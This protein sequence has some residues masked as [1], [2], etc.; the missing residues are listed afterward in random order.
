MIHELGSKQRIQILPVP[1]SCHLEQ[2]FVLLWVS[3]DPAVDVVVLLPIGAEGGVRPD[4]A[5]LLRA[6]AHDLPQAITVS[7]RPPRLDVPHSD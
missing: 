3:A 5:A 2:A 4:G 1:P 6:A 7:S